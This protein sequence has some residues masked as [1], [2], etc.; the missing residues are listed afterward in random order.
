VVRSALVTSA[1]SVAGDA[2][3][4][5]EGAGHPTDAAGR[6]VLAYRTVPGAYRAWLDGL[7]P[8]DRLNPTS[9]LLTSGDRTARRRLTNVSGRTLTFVAR[10]SGFEAHT[11]AVTPSTITLRPGRSATFRLDVSESDSAALDDGWLSW[12]SVRGSHGRIPVAITR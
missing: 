5:R 8:T 10:T 1:A 12:E 11:V 4:L 3:V 6:P 2:S 7:A 9:V